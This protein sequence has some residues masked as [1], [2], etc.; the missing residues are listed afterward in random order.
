M[1]VPFRGCF[2]K[3]S[4]RQSPTGRSDPRLGEHKPL[5]RFSL[6]RRGQFA[7]SAGFVF[8]RCSISHKARCSRR[9]VSNRCPS[10]LFC[11]TFIFSRFLLPGLRPVLLC[12]TRLSAAAASVSH[13][14]HGD[15]GLKTLPRHRMKC[16]AH[17]AC[18]DGRVAVLWRPRLDD[19]RARWDASGPLGGG[20]RSGGSAGVR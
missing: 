13:T 6:A 16:A 20:C 15:A 17:R 10:V 19:A 14:Q 11:V 8:G 3:P 18:A 5:F 1:Q 9:S 12:C 4:G 7:G 2:V